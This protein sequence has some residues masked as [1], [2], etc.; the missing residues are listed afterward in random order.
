VKKKPVGSFRGSISLLL[1][2]SAPPGLAQAVPSP[3]TADG[4]ISNN[5]STTLPQVE[6][7]GVR[8]SIASAQDTKRDS[9]QIVDSIVADDIAKLPDVSV[10]DA[11]QRVTG[12]QVA[13]D[14]GDGTGLTIRGLTQVET[15]LNGREV[16]TA[17]SGRSLDFTDFAAEAVAGIDVYKTASADQLEGGVGGLINLRTR[18]P[19]DFKGPQIAGSARWTRGD[20]VGREATQVTLLASNRWKTGDGELGA[21]LIL[22]D[23]DRAF[24]EDQKSQGNPLNRADLVSGQN[25]VAPN[26][27]SETTS[28]GQRT[29]RSA[30]L[31]LQWRLSPELELYAEGAY[32]RFLTRQD[33][34]QINVTASPTFAA[35]SAVL[36]PGTND[37]RGITWTNTPLSVLSF[38]RDTVDQTRQLAFGGSWTGP[39]LTVKADVSLTKGFNTLFFSGLN[40]G[41]TAASF[42]QNLDSGVPETRVGGT[43]LANPAN[44][45]YTGV[46]Y[47]YRPFEGELTA[48]RV[49]AEYTVDNSWINAVQA[50][51]RLARRSANNGAGLIFADAAVAGIAVTA[52]PQ[53][54]RVN[55]YDFF[56]GSTSLRNYLVGNLDTARDAQSLRTALGV[57][58]AIPASANPL[59]LWDIREETQ[60]AYLMARFKAATWPL[61]GN[62]GLRVVGTQERVSGAQSVPASGTLAPIQVRSDDTDYLPSLNLRYHLGPGL[63]LRGAASK[64]L[65]RPNFDQLSPS[66]TLVPNSINPALNQGSAGNPDLKPVRADNLDLAVEKYFGP[67]TA[68]YLT[69]FKKR[70]EG[71]VITSS[72]PEVVDG[73]SYQISRPRN[74]NTADIKGFELGYQQFFDFLPGWLGGLGLQANYTYVDSET[75]DTSLGAGV[76]LQNL[77][78]NSCNLIAMYERG[79]WS[80]R[81]AYNWRDRF[82]SGVTSIVG[83]GA[84]PIYTQAY[85]WLDASLSYRFTDQLSLLL[86]GNNLLNTRRS[87]YYGVATRPQSSWINDTQLSATLMLRFQ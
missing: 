13:R 20:L 46:T 77:S 40:L 50:G 65:T 8:A 53:Y 32:T 85:G 24:R 19:F 11:L 30:E 42:T 80:A 78:K 3:Q 34:Y 59:T 84:L 52:L 4:P 39:A 35:G 76:P 57:T 18:R 36:F 38:A 83:V 68:I 37:L 56:P 43:D 63:L 69:G 75:L 48:A 7:Q 86:A 1:A 73:V 15:T 29:R 51:L 21:L 79:P 66:L 2:C 72:S 45:R 67:A 71:F 62:V 60:T 33:S 6:V 25:V 28:L 44:F 49:D 22:A 87:S 9:Q 31:V 82:L 74:A 61:D 16:F 5:A 41:A 26:G 10:I 55:P 27:T 70:V 23:Q 17:G 47:R 12:V 81:V 14:R 54:A 58:A 64:T